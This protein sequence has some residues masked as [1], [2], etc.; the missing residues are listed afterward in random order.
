V[1][2]FVP[3]AAAV[4]LIVNVHDALAARLAPDRLTLPDPTAAVIVPPPQFPIKPLGGATLC[5]DGSVSVKP[6][7]L[8]ANLNWGSPD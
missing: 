1:F 5:P 3:E 7:P 2:V 8:R 6:I 4:T